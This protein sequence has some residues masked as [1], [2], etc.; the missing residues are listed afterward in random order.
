M[1]P[2]RRKPAKIADDFESVAKRLECDPSEEK[3]DRA[4]REIA[5]HGPEHRQSDQRSK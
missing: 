4:L 5:K 1:K 3:F 2:K